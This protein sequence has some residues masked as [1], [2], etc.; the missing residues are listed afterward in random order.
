R[1]RLVG[2][3]VN[4]RAG[5]ARVVGVKENIETV[6]RSHTTEV[7]AI[8]IDRLHSPLLPCGHDKIIGEI[9]VEGGEVGERRGQGSNAVTIVVLVVENHLRQL[10]RWRYQE[11]IHADGATRERGKLRLGGRSLDLPALLAALPGPAIAGL[12]QRK[13][14]RADGDKW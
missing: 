1:P 14:N 9:G 2:R 10:G 4:S 11:P 13:R 12:R 7:R 5:N 6:R 8:G 3:A